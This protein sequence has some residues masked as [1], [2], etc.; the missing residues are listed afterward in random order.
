MLTTSMDRVYDFA[1]TPRSNTDTAGVSFRFV[2]DPQQV[3]A[4]LEVREMDRREAD[5]HGEAFWILD[6]LPQPRETCAPL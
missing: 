4:A 5:W 2:P 1:T 6:W 3:Q